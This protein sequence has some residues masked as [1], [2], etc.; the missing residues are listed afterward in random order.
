MAIVDASGGPLLPREEK[1]TKKKSQKT[2]E[3]EAC[4]AGR[5]P[6]LIRALSYRSLLAAT[7]TWSVCACQSSSAEAHQPTRHHSAL[8]RWTSDAAC[9]HCLRSPEYVSPA[10][11]RREEPENGRKKKEK[12]EKKLA[13]ET[14]LAERARRHIPLP[15]PARSPSILVTLFAALRCEAAFGSFRWPSD[16]R[17]VLAAAV[18][19]CRGSPHRRSDAG[20]CDEVLLVFGE[21]LARSLPRRHVFVTNA[22]SAPTLG[23]P[24]HR[25]KQLSGPASSCLAR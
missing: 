24:A 8:R 10:R 1:R 3:L 9:F 15:S 25:V 17:G 6:A 11:L 20:V 14:S 18:R 5:G 21:N 16:A 2:R 22:A 12:K 13:S 4:V 19:S 7:P 23:P